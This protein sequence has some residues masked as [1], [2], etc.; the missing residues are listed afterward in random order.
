MQ[1]NII[2]LLECITQKTARDSGCES[3]V[4]RFNIF[5]LLGIENK[6]VI[7]CRFLGG[8]L[9]PNG[10]H[11]MGAFPLMCFVSQV[12]NCTSITEDEASQ[13]CVQLEEQIDDDRRVD[14]VIHLKDRAWPIEVKIWACDQDSQLYDY[15][16]YYQKKYQI[17]S[18]VYLTP[19]GRPPSPQSRG[20]LL[21]D[22]IQCISF[23]EN[24]YKWLKYILPFCDGRDVG[25]AIKH[26]IE[27]IENMTEKEKEV[28]LLRKALKLGGDEAVDINQ[29]NAALL[30]LNHKEEIQ[31][32]IWRRFLRKII[33]CDG[34]ELVDAENSDLAVDKYTLLRVKHNGTAVAWICVQQNLYL[35]C[36]KTKAG[37]KANWQGGVDSGYQWIYLAPNGQ[38]KYPLRDMSYL[39]DE[40]IDITDILQDIEGV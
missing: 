21:P 31:K 28:Q 39:K 29:I 15:Y 24:I 13:A 33:K 6:E 7:I 35:Y 32:E 40:E 38:K 9:D 18:I 4:G 14:I 10:S 34:F 30:L 17:D 26:F 3:D 2:T 16:S 12:L 11:Q 1:K 22:Q 37:A 19:T 8:L 27:V 5:S 23:S 25:V 20:S 36:K